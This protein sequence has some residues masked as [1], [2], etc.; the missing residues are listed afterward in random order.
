MRGKALERRTGRQLRR[1]AQAC[2]TGLDQTLDTLQP[3]L[4]EH[5]APGQ[6]GVCRLRWA[7]PDA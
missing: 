2:S 3:W 1:C 7:I 4:L 5:L 6:G